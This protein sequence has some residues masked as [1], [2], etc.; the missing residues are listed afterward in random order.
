MELSSNTINLAPVNP[1]KRIV[2]IDMIRGFAL[3]GVLFASMFDFGGRSIIWTQPEDQ[4]A[5][6][7][8]YIFFRTKSMRLFSML[9]A[10]GFGLQLMNA[11]NNLKIFIP[12]Y[13]RRLL[14][15]LLF[16]I[17]NQLNMGDILMVY[18]QLGLLLLLFIRF[19][20]KNLLITAGI[21]IILMSFL[22]NYGYS[23][24]YTP[25]KVRPDSEVRL[26]RAQNQAENIRKN[27]VAVNG[28]YKEVVKSRFK[29]LK[30]RFIVYKIYH[31][32]DWRFLR[33]FA[34]FLIGLAIL[35]TGI[36]NH[37]N[38]YRRKILKF[39][40]ISILLGIITSIIW[41]YTYEFMPEGKYLHPIILIIISLLFESFSMLFSLGY[42]GLIILMVNDKFWR[43]LVKPLA[44]VGRMALTAYLIQGIMM[45]FFKFGY[46]L[47]YYYK[48]RPAL[49]FTVT[50]SFFLFEIIFCN[51]W[52]RYFRYGPFEWLWRSLSY[53][54]IQPFIKD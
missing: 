27:S 8:M 10:F 50:I 37:L 3:F 34:A 39:T 44:A 49:L 16:G 4:I 11:K 5:Q 30:N 19:N 20:P 35:K 6:G 18:S 9:F 45:A 29:N 32:K 41:F 54:K 40:V 22:T 24:W 14:I 1:Q 23:K 25:D 31:G 36:H 15:L 51:I 28:T 38:R 26:E 46:G 2:E 43:R 17:Y 13:L 21:L 33:S 47:G 7:F 52:L 12:T 48:A 42:A 53:W